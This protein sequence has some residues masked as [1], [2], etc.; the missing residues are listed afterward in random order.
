VSATS[1]R[2]GPTWRKDGDGCF[3]PPKCSENDSNGKACESDQNEEKTN[4]KKI[5]LTSEAILSLRPKNTKPLIECEKIVDITNNLIS[6]EPIPPSNSNPLSSS[7][8]SRLWNQSARSQQNAKS[9]K[10]GGDS[11]RN[12]ES[13]REHETKYKAEN[14]SSDDLWDD[15][16]GVNGGNSFDDIFGGDCSAGL[17]LEDMAA[18]SGK[19]KLEMDKLAERAAKVKVLEE[20]EELEVLER[21]SKQEK[22]HQ[23][24]LKPMSLAEIEGESSPSGSNEETNPNNTTML[25]FFNENTQKNEQLI[26]NKENLAA[27]DE[28]VTQS[29]GEK[30]STDSLV[31][32]SKMPFNFP[33]LNETKQVQKSVGASRDD[34]LSSLGLISPSTTQQ[35]LVIDSHHTRVMLEQQRRMQAQEASEKEKKRKLL[36][37]QQVFSL[38][39]RHHQQQQH[40]EQQLRTELESQVAAESQRRMH[41][42]QEQ[43]QIQQLQYRLQKAHSRGTSAE[44]WHYLDPQGSIQGPFSSHDMREWFEE[45]YFGDSLLVRQGSSGEFH[46]LSLLFPTSSHAF[47]A[48]ANAEREMS[49]LEQM[50]A[51]YSKHEVQRQEQL[52][53]G[54][55]RLA[56]IRQDQV[57]L[58]HAQS[59]ELRAFKEA[60]I[61]H[62]ALKQNENRVA[63]E[64]LKMMYSRS[65]MP[66]VSSQPLSSPWG[67]K[68]SPFPSIGGQNRSLKAKSPSQRD[69]SIWAGIVLPDRKIN[70]K[71]EAPLSSRH[72]SPPL[73]SFFFQDKE[74]QDWQVRPSSNSPLSMAGQIKRPVTVMGS[75][76]TTA[77]A[78]STM[79]RNMAAWV[80]IELQK[81]GKSQDTTLL[82]FCMSIADPNEV[83]DVLSSYL[84]P[85]PMA[86][87][88][89]LAFLQRKNLVK[90][91]LW[92]GN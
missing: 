44:P 61:R 16:I 51:E 32:D 30:K 14:L 11:E 87:E 33:P 60:Y 3:N 6:L 12:R 25:P 69:E 22:N 48:S 53:N 56:Q 92:G 15:P 9:H 31:I 8:I 13:Y 91:G 46:P 24:V 86:T 38:Q 39:Q 28:I 81:L 78:T 35:Q 76:W 75:G 71:V 34:I 57:R 65:D 49:R 50:K 55:H 5:T 62:E 17:N 90:A 4:G 52:R 83:R 79:P 29:E 23:D 82:D 37:R 89:I 67:G 41:Q 1:M 77:N 66:N 84:G 70:G 80:Q 21:K 26:Q 43:S 7:E 72:A 2:L 20:K 40:V 42:K 68:T 58:A 85:S 47:A 88:F 10:R 19:F 63:Q 36:I 59:E 74:A 73:G 18:Q 54:Q 27:S 64:E 45:G